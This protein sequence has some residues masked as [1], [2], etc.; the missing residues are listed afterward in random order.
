MGSLGCVTQG[1]AMGFP[2]EGFDA[3]DTLRA[4]SQARCTALYGVPTMFVAML[5]QAGRAGYD[6]SSLRTGIMAGTSCPIEVMQRVIDEMH[7]S[8]VTIA[9][10]DDRDLP[11]LVPVL[12][13]RSDR[14]AGP[15]P[16]AASFRTWRQGRSTA[17]APSHRSASRGSCAS[18]ATRSCAATG[19]TRSGPGRASSA[20]GCTRATSRPL[21]EDGFC[22]IVGR[23]KDMIIRGGENVY[24]RE[25]ED[26]LF[27]H[28]AIREAQ[29]FG[30]P[31]AKY[32]E[33]VCAWVVPHE[34]AALTPEEVNCVLRWTDCALQGAEACSYGGR[35]ADDGDGEAAEV[36][37][38]GG[39]AGGVRGGHFPRLNHAL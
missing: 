36:R 33:Q 7:M 39:G 17:R 10:G 21:D 15:R 19:T 14:A 5:A 9:Y 28:P 3:A 18:A 16:W 13:R 37:D 38:A 29:V 23:V 27:R 12:R 20:A 22:R 1:A 34:G 31:D 30:I 4:I 24:P 26:Y 2:G 11:G 6:L 35:A 8:E 25:V 32:G